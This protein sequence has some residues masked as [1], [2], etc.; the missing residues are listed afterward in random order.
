MMAIRIV[1]LLVALTVVTSQAVEDTKKTHSGACMD[2]WTHFGGSCYYLYGYDNAMAHSDAF[3]KCAAMAKGWYIHLASFHDRKEY[4]WV[5]GWLATQTHWKKSLSTWI[6]LTLTP[7]K[8]WEWHDDKKLNYSDAWAPEQPDG[9]GACAEIRQDTGGFNDQ[10]CSFVNQFLCEYELSALPPKATLLPSPCP[11]GWGYHNYSCYLFGNY[12][13]GRNYSASE[14]ECSKHNSHLAN[15]QYS[16]EY[17]YAYSM[18]EHEEHFHREIGVWIGLRLVDNVWRWG[19]GSKLEYESV[20]AKGEPNGHGP[21][22]SIH[23]ESGGIGDSPCDHTKQYLC[24]YELARP[25]SEPKPAKVTICDTN[26]VHYEHSCYLFVGQDMKKSQHKAATYCGDEHVDAHLIDL[27]DL[28]EYEWIM[29]EVKSRP[30]FD[31]NSDTWIGLTR[32]TSGDSKHW[33]WTDHTELKYNNTWADNNPS[34]DTD[35][36]GSF[37]RGAGGFNDHGCDHEEQ[38]ICE[39]ELQDDESDEES[40]S[41]VVVLA[42]VALALVCLVLI[43]IMARAIRKCYKQS[44]DTRVKYSGITTD[45]KRSDPYV[46]IRITENP[47][48]GQYRDDDISARPYTDNDENI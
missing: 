23:K 40:T 36:C 9:N 47:R 48:Q 5:Y 33:V 20:W 8:I 37:H 43:V 6:G 1:F 35:M 15:L 29:E 24:E 34:S 3:V 45:V 28:Y 19:D 41:K 30:D 31:Q 39:Y 4:E 38:F 10:N 17:V 26:W 18:L 11:E 46:D 16:G 42:A 32:K 14:H 2:G 27:Q 21:C 13:H 7:E 25:T 44:H 22:G 12:L